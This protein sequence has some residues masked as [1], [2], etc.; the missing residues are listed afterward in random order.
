MSQAPVEK[1]ADR[2]L[3]QEIKSTVHSARTELAGGGGAMIR[4]SRLAW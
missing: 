2:R 3:T 4:R 1:I